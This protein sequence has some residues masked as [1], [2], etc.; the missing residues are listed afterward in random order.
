MSSGV[1][2][3][4]TNSRTAL[5]DMVFVIISVGLAQLEAL[6]NDVLQR[7]RCDVIPS[8]AMSGHASHSGSRRRKFWMVW[9][10]VCMRVYTLEFSRD[11]RT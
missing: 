4:V 3:S 2:T 9:A 11:K 5:V 8:S 7:H 10:V 1:Y 6:T